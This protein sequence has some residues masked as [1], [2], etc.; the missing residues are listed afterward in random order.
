VKLWSDA[1]AEFVP[2]LA[3]D[4]EIRKVICSTNAIVIWSPHGPV[5]HVDHE[6]LMARDLPG[7][8]GYLP[9]S[10]TRMG[11]PPEVWTP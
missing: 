11:P 5:L 1:W 7:G 2:F 6:G 8:R 9:P 3:F 10:S 4:V